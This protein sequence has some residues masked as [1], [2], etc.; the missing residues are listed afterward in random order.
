MLDT[1]DQRHG[2]T[3]AFAECISDPR[4]QR[5]INKKLHDMVKQWALQIACGYEDANE[6]DTLRRDLAI[7][8]AVNR[9]RRLILTLLTS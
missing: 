4:D 8:T 6:A 2:I 5:Y 1:I 3:S 7:K 9:F